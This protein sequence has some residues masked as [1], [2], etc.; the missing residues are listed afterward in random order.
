MN[1]QNHIQEFVELFLRI[2]NQLTQIQKKPIELEPGVS[3]STS[4]IHLIDTIGQHPFTNVTELATLLGVTKGAVSQQITNL[5]KSGFI[6]ISQ[7]GDN[8]KNKLLNLTKKGR[9][10]YREHNNL[11]AELYADIGDTLAALDNKQQQMIA[12]LMLNVSQSIQNYQAKL[13][14]E[15]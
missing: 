5:D 11:H 3:L 10:I 15:G 8:R 6:Q 1:S 7:T 2:N 12:E 13:A 4:A 9:S 14:K